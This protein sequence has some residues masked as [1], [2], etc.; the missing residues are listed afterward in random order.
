MTRPRPDAGDLDL[1]RSLTSISARV[2]QLR[3]HWDAI[4]AA[5][6]AHANA[7][8][9]SLRLVSGRVIHAETVTGS[10]FA[11]K[12][13]NPSAPL[14]GEVAT[15]QFLA[16]A[17]CPVPSVIATDLTQGEP[18]WIATEWAG[19]RTLDAF[20][21]ECNDPEADIAGLHL[22]TGVAQIERAFAQVTRRGVPGAA[23]NMAIELFEPWAS[24]AVDGLAWLFSTNVTE[25]LH[26]AMDRVVTTALS[27]PMTAG[28][29]DY[30]A[31][32]VVVGNADPSLTIIDLGSIGFDW[33]GRRLA[34]Y[35]MSVRSGVPGGRFRTALTPASV[36]QFAQHLAEIHGGDL[37][38][39]IYEV[40]A[41]ALLIAAIAAT[42]L[43]A[44]DTGAA[45]PERTVGW[46]AIET[47]RTSLRPV[48][49]RTL[50]SDGPANDVREFLARN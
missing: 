25:P 19:T 5:V 4:S 2:P 21:G 14:A 8:I 23:R 38:S 44:V 35:A 43:R 26:T 28:P 40:D 46:G 33:P 13:G 3:G 10:S 1:A 11:V 36:T 12:F 31:S 50:S 9:S 15:L 27:A 29:L 16:N 39:S 37:V 34:Q 48:V 49:L 45:S 18:E 17:E 42:Q 6:E 47:R 7:P 32:N 22:V 24:H 20:L 41:H 30:H